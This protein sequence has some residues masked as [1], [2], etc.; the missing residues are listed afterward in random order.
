[1]ANCQLRSL[2]DGYMEGRDP[3][4]GDNPQLDLN[5]LACP[6]RRS[7]RI[8]AARLAAEAKQRHSSNPQPSTSASSAHSTSASSTRP[9]PSGSSS[10]ASSSSVAKPPRGTPL[11]GFLGLRAFAQCFHPAYARRPATSTAPPLLPARPT[12]L[13][14]TAPHPSLPTRPADGPPPEE[15]RPKRHCSHGNI[16]AEKRA[17]QKTQRS[18]RRGD[19]LT[20]DNFSVLENASVASTGWEGTRPPT[21][22][23]KKIDRLYGDEPDA[24]GLQKHLKHFFPPREERATFFVDQDGLIS[25]YRSYRVAELMARADEIQHA[26][27]VLVDSDRTSHAWRE[28]YRKG[29]RGDHIA[30]IFGHHRQSAQV[31]CPAV[32]GAA[33]A[34]ST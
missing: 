24:K 28:H 14:A 15:P 2:L 13:P 34:A 3:L 22:A 29:Q 23:R 4:T 10:S 26:H 11:L 12:S 21:L 30:I 9:R 20:S 17:E 33:A 6:P 18:A 1:M 27:D 7:A 19:F 32:H 31:C 16:P 25:I 8:F 5:A